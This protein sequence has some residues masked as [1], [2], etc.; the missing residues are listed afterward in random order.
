MRRRGLLWA[1][2]ALVVLV[3]GALL[4]PASPAYLPTL[5]SRHGRYHDGHSVRTWVKAL[6]SPDA[7]VQIR[8]IHALGAIGPEAAEAVPALSRILLDSP[9]RG[10]RI[11]AALA[12]YKMAPASREAVPALARA[13]EDKEPLVRMNVVLALMRLRGESRPAVAA[14]IRALGADGNRTNVGAFPF[15]IR[16]AVAITLGVASAGS[17]DAVPALSEALEHAKTGGMR[18][19][20]ARGLG[21][22]GPEARAAAPQ[23]RALLRDRE[24]YVRESAEEALQKIEAPPS[25]H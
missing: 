12:L 8:A 23:L 5:Y 2:G 24:N 17:A 15:T 4:I 18:Q 3:V 7:E 11:E 6:D 19:A 10:A 9:S 14:L 16:E 1:A 20:A 22:V 21:E 25:V 13:L